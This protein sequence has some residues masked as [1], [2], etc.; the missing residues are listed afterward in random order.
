MQL[1]VLCV[2]AKEFT[3]EIFAVLEGVMFS[4]GSPFFD[5]SHPENLVHWVLFEG[6]N[7]HCE[8]LEIV[9]VENFCDFESEY[10]R[11]WSQTY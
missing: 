4:I 2:S 11:V 10:P 5:T 7:F 9:I 6:L 8:A 3:K 1:L